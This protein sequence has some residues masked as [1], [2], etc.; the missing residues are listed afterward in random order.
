[1]SGPCEARFAL[2]PTERARRGDFVAGAFTVPQAEAIL[3]RPL[4]AELGLDDTTLHLC[5]FTGVTLIPAGTLRRLLRAP[6]A[7][8]RRT[9]LIASANSR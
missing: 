8:E 9:P 7:Y 1:M 2:V 4:D 5:P 3:G 6:G